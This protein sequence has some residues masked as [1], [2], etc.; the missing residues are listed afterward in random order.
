MTHSKHSHGED[1]VRSS[2]RAFDPD[3]ATSRSLARTACIVR[4]SI[5]TVQRPGDVGT[6]KISHVDL[7]KELWRFEPFTLPI[8]VG[9]TDTDLARFGPP[10]AAR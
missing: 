2:W 3:K 6:M 4:L 9:D 1:F 5:V 10:S 7:D 8:N